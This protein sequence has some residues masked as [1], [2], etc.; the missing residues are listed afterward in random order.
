MVATIP[1]ESILLNTLSLQE[2][3][4]SSAVENIIT[5]QDEIFKA[6]LFDEALAEPAAKEVS[7]YAAALREGVDLVKKTDVIT[8]NHMIKIQQIL[9]Q[10]NAEFRK[11]TGT[12]LKNSRTGETVY[13]PPQEHSE[14][15]KLMKN[16]EAYINND[17][18][19]QLDPLIKMAVI[20]HQF[21]SIHPFYDGNGRTGRIVCILYLYQQG[22]LQVPVLYLSRFIIQNKEDYYRLLQEVRDTGNYAPWLLYMLEGVEQTAQQ[23]IETVKGIK[24]MMMDYKS[25]IREELPKIYSQDLLNNL[26]RHPYTKIEYLEKDI[27]KTRITATKYLDTLAEH[28]FLRKERV[29]K[30]NYYINEPLMDVLAT[31]PKV[32][33]LK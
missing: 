6:E 8:S 9:E 11:L 7:R 14:I 24:A 5:T 22:L 27:G 15:L 31:V 10:N 2:A 33:K 30:Y 25:R 18:L 13:T 19:C 1:N 32:N 3:Q 4:D 26:F 12:A 21:E 29:G 16:L 20:H 17:D 28:G 23:T